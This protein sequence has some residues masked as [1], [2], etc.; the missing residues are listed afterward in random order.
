MKTQL[1]KNLISLAGVAL[2][3]SACGEMKKDPTTEYSDVKNGLVRP[4]SIK[5]RDQQYLSRELFD[6]YPAD[7]AVL[8]FVEGEAKSYRIETRAISGAVYDIAL[9]KKPAD[10]MTLTKTEK[11]GVYVLTWT[12]ERGHIPN[13]EPTR[14]H[15]L[16]FELILL[17]GSDARATGIFNSATLPIDR[18]RKHTI[19][20][21]RTK[22]QPVIS[23]VSGLQERVAEGKQFRFSIEVADPAGHAGNMP[24]LVPVEI[25]AQNGELHEANGHSFIRPDP[26]KPTPERNEDG[27]WVFHRIFDTNLAAVPLPLD[28]DGA[29]DLA[30]SSVVVRFGYMI[31]GAG[32]MTSP[33][34]IERVTID[35]DKNIE[36]PT[37][38]FATGKQSIALETGVERDIEIAVL[39]TNTRAKVDLNLEALR[40]TL[41]G[42]PGA[43]TIACEDMGRVTNIKNCALTW[44]VPCDATDLKAEYPLTVEAASQ[45]FDRTATAK[46]TKTL[47]IVKKSENCRAAQAVAGGK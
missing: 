14:E 17:P 4:H 29:V 19:S 37:I 9:T 5:S 35:L 34:K 3:F 39:S 31:N 44:K 22:Q 6:I 46:L 2:L 40:A 18:T 33:E 47:K 7:N 36:A 16:T 26:E 10:G 13:A 28:K 11:P 24:K 30:A 20:V 38:R 8:N 1:S 21:R 45:L 23:R 27:T 15:E 42:L 12:P 43:P 41:A 25:V 32:G